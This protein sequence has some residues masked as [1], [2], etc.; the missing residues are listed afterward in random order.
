M[1]IFEGF[2]LPELRYIKRDYFKGY[3]LIMLRQRVYTLGVL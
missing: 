1:T 2:F 3:S